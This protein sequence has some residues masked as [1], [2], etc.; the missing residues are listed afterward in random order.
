MKLPCLF[1]PCTIRER[2][3]LLNSITFVLILILVSIYTYQLVS[4]ENKLVTME[5][6]DD[7][8]NSILELR[9]Y[10]KNIMLRLNEDSILKA[11]ESLGEIEAYF[12][13]L[14]PKISAA[15]KKNS[16]QHLK[17]NLAGYRKIFDRWCA[18]EKCISG[19]VRLK[20]SQMIRLQ[21]QE[22]VNNAAEL[23][24]LNRKNISLGFKEILFWLTFMPAIIFMSGA[25]LFFSQVRNILN[26]LAFLKQGTK[27]L[28]AGEF[29]VIPTIDTSPDEISGLINNFNQMVETLEQKQEQLV[30]S[31][32]MAS[33]GTFSSGIAHE[34]N[35]PLNNISLSTDT[36]LED[37]DS[38]EKGEVR[39]ILDDIMAQTERAS[40]IVRNL[41]DFSRVQSSE[42]EPLYVDFVLHKT[43]DLIA[44]ELRIHKVD[45]VKDIADLLPRVNGDL[46]KL[47][48]V[49]L[50]LIINAEQAIEN[51]GTITVSARQTDNGYV[52]TD[53]CDTGPG[54]AQENLEQIFDPF[55]TTKEA[56][57]GTGLGLSIVYG[58]VKEHGGYIEVASKLGEGT[59]F[60]VYLPV[61]RD[62][63]NKDSEP[64][65]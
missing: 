64:L 59:T 24:R 3:M 5:H 13:E 26:R 2:L 46:Q 47:Q 38:M 43:T 23:V 51:Y 39:E 4:L 57:K 56:G 41:L 28:A 45:L 42:M 48:Q 20:D 14:A 25:L 61:Y 22:L 54:I 37:I 7:L 58:I 9:R 40:K 50:N 53:V 31:K 65:W 32:K 55:F 44:N 27:D 17:R 35:N 19:A 1:K 8:F 34:I 49:F 6:V 30:Q 62:D 18:D 16:F 60:S 63:E 33:I 21:G 11:E 52:R 10:E 36:L 29:K 12:V 15:T